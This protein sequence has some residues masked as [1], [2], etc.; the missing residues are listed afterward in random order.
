LLLGA[1]TALQAGYLGGMFLR[2]LLER[3]GIAA[4]MEAERP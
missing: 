3:Y 4:A 1:Q 2:S